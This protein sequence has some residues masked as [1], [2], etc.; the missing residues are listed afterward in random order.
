ME[1]II[2]ILNEDEENLKVKI[3]RIQER[4]DT[5]YL[6]A[7]VIGLDDITQ[8][9][10]GMKIKEL[11]RER[12][13]YYIAL[14]NIEFQK[15]KVKFERNKSLGINQTKIDAEAFQED[16][17]KIISTA[18]RYIEVAEFDGYINKNE[19]K[20]YNK[21]IE[22]EPNKSKKVSI[23][24]R[25]YTEV[26]KLKKKFKPNIL[27]GKTSIDILYHQVAEKFNKSYGSVK[28]NHTKIQRQKN[29]KS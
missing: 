1:E 15:L 13:K 18:R 27:S 2:K 10:L 19:I 3:N 17:N 11:E 8:G 26:E 25:D 22:A 23:E 7:K 28:Q 14:K 5:I 24:Q 20:T 16:R 21:L 6:N 12:L 4:I 29:K 9:E